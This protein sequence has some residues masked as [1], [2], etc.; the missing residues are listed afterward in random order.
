LIGLG[1]GPLVFDIA[2]RRQLIVGRWG[3]VSSTSI[4]VALWNEGIAL[5]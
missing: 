3:V 2:A 4:Y 5:H 1:Y